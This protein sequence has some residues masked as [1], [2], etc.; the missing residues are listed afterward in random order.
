MDRKKTI[1]Y[2]ITRV[3]SPEVVR[4]SPYTF[5]WMGFHVN[6]LSI[7]FVA[8]PL[9]QFSDINLIHNCYSEVFHRVIRHGYSIQ[10][11]Q[12]KYH[13]GA[14]EVKN[15]RRTIGSGILLLSSENG[16]LLASCVCQ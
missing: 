12:Q 9:G 10:K 16:E 6:K 13:L 2:P 1:K 4:T 7:Y 15:N 8:S 14:D 3:R 5:K 11:K